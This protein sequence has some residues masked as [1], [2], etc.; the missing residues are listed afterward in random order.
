ML[1]SIVASVL[2]VASAAAQAAGAAGVSCPIVPYD[3]RPG[4]NLECVR[5]D[6]N[7]VYKDSLITNVVVTG[8][9]FNGHV[10][11]QCVRAVGEYVDLRK[12]SLTHILIHPSDNWLGF[13]YQGK[14]CWITEGN[15]QGES[16][17]ACCKLLE[18]HV[19]FC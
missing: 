4:Y 5:G 15:V 11:F 9:T 3:A 7:G 17:A 6:K 18:N 2:F 14:L 8:G 16:K 10:N 1:S 19:R 12:C 13:A